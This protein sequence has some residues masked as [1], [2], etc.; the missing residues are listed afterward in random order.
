[1]LQSVFLWMLPLTQKKINKIP[2]ANHIKEVYAEKSIVKAIEIQINRM[3][4]QDTPAMKTAS[5]I[6]DQEAKEIVERLIREYDFD[7]EAIKRELEKRPLKD[8]SGQE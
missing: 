5:Y 7:I 3:K 8:V 6:Y 2:Y 1:M 4:V